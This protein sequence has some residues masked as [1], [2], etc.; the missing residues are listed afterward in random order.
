VRAASNASKAVDY[1]YTGGPGGDVTDSGNYS[2]VI[3]VDLDF[4]ANSVPGGIRVYGLDFGN[5]MDG[6]GVQE[7]VFSRGST[8]GGADAPAVFILE[9]EDFSSPTIILEDLSGVPTSLALLQNY[10]NPFNPSTT[11]KYAINKP[12]RVKLTVYDAVGR[13]I[14][15]LVNGFHT[16]NVYTVIW[17]GKNQSGINVSSGMYFY[18]LETK[19]GK[20]IKKMN[21]LK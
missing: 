5:D 20:I 3:I 18:E 10:P 15:T 8:R 9:P 16:R 6:D 7:I 21:F 1:Q 19:F 2:P 4:F 12:T 11:I 14:A 17:N 13:K